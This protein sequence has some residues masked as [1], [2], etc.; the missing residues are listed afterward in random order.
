MVMETSFPDDP[1]LETKLFKDLGDEI[2]F[3][4]S[5]IIFILLQIQKFR[6]IKISLH[7]FVMVIC[8]LVKRVML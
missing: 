3:N 8:H 7:S 1:D 6:M 5:I 4:R 2:A